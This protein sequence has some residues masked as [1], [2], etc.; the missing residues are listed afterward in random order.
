MR[1]AKLA[2][3][4]AA[5]VAASAG[6]Q[7]TPSPAAASK[8][9]APTSSAPAAPTARPAPAAAVA[10]AE[11]AERADDWPSGLGGE[12]YRTANFSAD[13]PRAAIEQFAP[14]I[15]RPA[16]TY[17]RRQ[18]AT[19]G[20]GEQGSASPRQEQP[21]ASNA[22]AVL[23][24]QNQVDATRRELAQAEQQLSNLQQE[25]S[26]G[27]RVMQNAQRAQAQREIDAA[28]S[29]LSQVEGELRRAESSR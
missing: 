21:R 3:L 5:V 8:S 15:E 14:R 17:S 19:D 11:P 26:L 10:G 12:T 27:A 18:A 6:C 2:L 22:S 20:E 29:R 4:V 23:A 7:R 13:A 9:V 24:L 25:R 16:P 28:R 1:N